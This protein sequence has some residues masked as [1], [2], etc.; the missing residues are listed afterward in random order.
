[1]TMPNFLVIGAAKCGTDSLCHY[2]GQHPDIFIS[3]NR[4]PNFFVAE[5]QDHIPYHGPGDVVALENM[6]VSDL[7]DYQSLFA[8][9]TT[10]TA[11]GEGTA[12]YIYFEDAPRRIRHHIP[13]AKLIA[14]LRNPVDRAYS[15]YTMLLRDG[16]EPLVDFGA[17]LDAEEERVKREWEPIWYY[18]RMGFYSRQLERYYSLFDRDQLR[19]VIYDDFDSNPQ[20]VLR[21][22]FEFLNVDHSFVPDTSRRTNVSLVPRHHRLHHIVAGEYRLKTVVKKLVPANARQAVKRPLVNRNLTRPAPLNDEVRG[23]LV[24]LFRDDILETQ[25]L[26]GRDLSHWLA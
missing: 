17:A 4:E 20:P 24:D 10:E 18:A 9:V 13:D 3:P 22:M 21:Q 7:A 5:G 6:W 1:M 11:V 2:L 15:A 14:V 16:R 12:W 26:L 19:V 23:R 8:G 25:D